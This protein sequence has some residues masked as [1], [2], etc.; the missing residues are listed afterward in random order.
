MPSLR[1]Y[2]VASFLLLPPRAQRLACQIRI[3]KSP[4]I[5]A[6][7]HHFTQFLS[8]PKFLFVRVASACDFKFD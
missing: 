4:A 3:D 5:N 7:K 1:H 2:D 6:P 8:K